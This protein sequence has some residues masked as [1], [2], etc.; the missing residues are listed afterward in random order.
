VGNAD[1]RACPP[2]LAHSRALHILKILVVEHTDRHR[3]TPLKTAYSLEMSSETN[4]ATSSP[5]STTTSL[6]S[7]RPNSASG[8]DAGTDLSELS[9]KDNKDK[10]EAI[11]VSEEQKEKAA[12]IKK[13]ANVAFGSASLSFIHS[14][15]FN[16]DR[17]DFSSK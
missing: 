8:S 7:S 14:T 6:Y 17:I 5:I 15:A 11:N 4:S 2:P 10:E 9:I 13:E 12:V 3:T 16:I 1:R